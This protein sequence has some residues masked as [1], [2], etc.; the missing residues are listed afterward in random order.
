MPL[1]FSNSGGLPA[2]QP[3][4][5]AQ[6][7]AVGGDYSSAILIEELSAPSGRRPRTITL[8]GPGLPFRGANWGGAN[9][10]ATEWYPGN[11]DEGTTQNLGPTEKNTN[12]SGRWSRSLMGKAPS[13]A[14]D[15][16]GSPIT[17]VDPATL[18][19]LLE[20]VVRGGARVRVTWT[21]SSPNPSSR[22][23]VVRE[24]HA[25]SWDFK[26]DRA[27]DI[28]W[29]IEWQWQSR[30]ARLQ[31][32][33]SVRDGSIEA[34]SARL[35]LAMADLAQQLATAP[36]IQS[37]Q[38]IANSAN[39]FTLGQLETIASAPAAAATALQRQVLQLQSQV[40]QVAAIAR[41][42]QGEPA[43][44]VGSAIAAASS[45]IA[46]MRSFT[47][48][49]G[50][51]PIELMASK[52]QVADQLRAFRYL[53]GASDGAS[54]VSSAAQALVEQIAAKAPTPAGAGALSPT[55]ARAAAG[56]ML[57][58]HVCRDGDTPARLSVRY[59]GS[60]DHGV[61]I[62]QANRLPW[63]TVSFNKGQVLF[64]ARLRTQQRSA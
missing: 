48:Q 50:R 57:A 39:T 37:N 2:P 42:V 59:Y 47:D 52:Q 30:G 19:T 18:W 7:A 60:M 45:S 14:T 62:L 9:N 34:A 64:V 27:Q 38:K 53:A 63:H 55:S 20:D 41:T 36:I 3:A 11:G 5:Q 26:P 29:E 16:Q 6:A 17:V 15:D 43:Q 22:A 21:Q 23:K 32:T 31:T 49:Q 4:P 24:G 35:N 56:D 13:L 46:A 33:S 12:W 58:V 44:V 10:L 28:E 25:A 51:V 8:Q 54:S 1:D 40:K 61:D